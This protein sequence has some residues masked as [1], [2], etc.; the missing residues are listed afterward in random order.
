MCNSNWHI[1]S[2]K[3]YEIGQVSFPGPTPQPLILV[4][5]MRVQ[6][7]KLVVGYAMDVGKIRLLRE[8]LE[9]DPSLAEATQRF[10]HSSL[11]ALI[12]YC[13]KCHNSSLVFFCFKCHGNYE[14]RVALCHAYPVCPK[15]KI[16]VSFRLSVPLPRPRPCAWLTIG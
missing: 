15:Y 11:S 14:R 9:K 3:R 4:E 6:T 16:F 7:E 8:A 10:S 1:A 12:G 2:Y 5:P 13:F